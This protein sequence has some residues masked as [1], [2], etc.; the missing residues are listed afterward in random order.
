MLRKPLEE[1]ANSERFNALRSRFLNQAL[2]YLGVPYAK[3]Y[4]EKGSPDYNAPLF[5]D[6]CALVRRV[7]CD[8]KNEFGFRVGKWNQAYQ[9]DT[10][11]ITIEK[12][13][14]LKPGDLVF[15]SGVYFNPE[16]KRQKHNMVHVEIWLGDGEKTIGARYHRGRVQIH[17]SYKFVSKSYHSM[18]YHFK[19]IDTWLNGICRSFCSEHPWTRSKYLNHGKKSIF[20]AQ[21]EKDSDSESA[22]GTDDEDQETGHKKTEDTNT[23]SDEQELQ[24]LFIEKISTSPDKSAGFFDTN[25]EQHIQPD[26]LDNPNHSYDYVDL[27]ESCYCVQECMCN[28]NTCS[29]INKEY[30]NNLGTT[31]KELTGMDKH[32]SLAP[33][34]ATKKQADKSKASSKM[35]NGA[36]Q[37]TNNTSSR[38]SRSKSPSKAPLKQPT[39]LTSSTSRGRKK[40]TPKFY[41]GG[42]NGVALVEKPLLDKGWQRIDDNKDL[43]YYLKWVEC[44]SNID[45]KSFRPGEQLVN[46]IPNGSCLT[47]KTGMLKSLHE[48]EKLANRKTGGASSDLDLREFYPETYRIENR[49][50]YEKF[51]SVFKDGETWICKP[52]G[53]NQG[54]GIFLVRNP[55]ELRDVIEDKDSE[56]RRSQ[57]STRIIS[58]YIAN[59]LLV[60]NCKFDIRA[61]MLITSTTPYLV[62]YHN[63]Y[64]R[65][66]CEAYSSQSTDL[67]SHLTNQ[68]VQKKHP[69]Y[70]EKRDDSVWSFE[71]LNSY[72]EEHYKESKGLVDDWVLTTMTDRIKEIMLICFKAVENKLERKCGY[73][74]LLG[75]DFMVDDNMNIWLLECNVNPALFTN[76]EPLRQI[77]PDIV[78]ETLLIC[79]EAFENKCNKKKLNPLESLKTFEVLFDEERKICFQKAE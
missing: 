56:K 9:F 60:N 54:K 2:K 23:K 61:Y 65:V 35:Q 78:E 32:R 68:F 43:S 75:F 53:M 8:L 51:T 22:S 77:I 52:S 59:P 40:P 13:E 5:L 19:S 1:R 33:G 24:F 10:L 3:K 47:T 64:I 15:I 66:A 50:D 44:K 73:F 31:A 62:L 38:R 48:Y 71:K 25:S 46:H 45:Y 6:C 41:I 18:V 21:F 39:V 30:E 27:D 79:I 28:C 58:R 29:A 55:K 76:C 74:D 17:D 69:G 12:E 37:P 57:R 34:N 20:N 63:G 36:H 67:T 11:P 42:K 49:F 26:C 16:R 14:D 4:H 70:Q 7:L 72:I